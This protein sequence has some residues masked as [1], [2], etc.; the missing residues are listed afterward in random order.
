MTT[1]GDFFGGERGRLF[2]LAYRLLGSAADAE[3][4]VQETFLRWHAADQQAIETPGTWLTKVVTNL[5]LNHLA[6]ARVRHERTGAWLPEPVLTGHGALG[7]LE[8]A[9]QRESVSLAL[10]VLLERLTAVERAVFVLREAFGYPYEDIAALVSTSAGNCRQ[11]HSRARR[12]IGDGRPRFAAPDDQARRLAE[13]FIAAARSGD[14]VALEDLLTA[15]VTA[16]VD[17]GPSVR[18]RVRGRD[19]VGRLAGTA[20][21]RFAPRTLVTEA[22]AAPALLFV[23]A[24]ALLG[25]TVL[26]I[27]QTRVRTLH[28][29]TDPRKL[30]ATRRHLLAAAR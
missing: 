5:C 29:V 4:I 14:L 16:W 2:G 21:A 22:N 19:E 26:D 15:D 17:A 9:E 7:P 23:R 27:D 28:T 20:L 30:T 3:D 11:V 13:R 25:V 12:R 10:L 24:D 6:S 18:R 8:T 1:I